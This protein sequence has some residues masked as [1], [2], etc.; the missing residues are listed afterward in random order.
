MLAPTLAWDLSRTRTYQL[1]EV[2]LN[3]TDDD[4]IDE[5]EA[6]GR[7]SAALLADVLE[8]NRHYV[9]D[10]IERLCSHDE[11]VKV[12]PALYDTP[13]QAIEYTDVDYDT[14]T[15]AGDDRD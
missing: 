5:I 7:A 12:A 10:R 4:I 2:K 3:P 13:E 15:P 8:K 1:L 11:L 9:Q 6:N 14:P